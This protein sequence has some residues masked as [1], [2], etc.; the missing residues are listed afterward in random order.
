MLFL[1]ETQSCLCWFTWKDSKLYLNELDL[2]SYDYDRIDQISKLPVTITTLMKSEK[3]RRLI[4]S[5]GIEHGMEKSNLAQW[6]KING[7]LIAIN[8]V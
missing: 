2:M 3:R 8:T 6:P 4:E 1:D 5:L 7:D